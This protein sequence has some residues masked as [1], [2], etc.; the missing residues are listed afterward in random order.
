MIIGIM[1]ISLYIPDAGSLK[2]KRF[3]IKSVKDKIKNKFNVSLAEEANDLWQ[4]V[5]LYAACISTDTQH[6][7]STLE[8][9]KNMIEKDPQIEILGY[10]LELS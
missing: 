5:E 8:N 10:S 2:A 9:V 4:R 1:R 6:V 7:N 3:V